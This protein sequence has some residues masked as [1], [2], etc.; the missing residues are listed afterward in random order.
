MSTRN[1][2]NNR[3]AVSFVLTVYNKEY[4]LPA[5]LD[6]VVAQSGDFE[7]EYV[8]VNDGSTDDSLSLIRAFAERTPNVVIVDQ[9]N[10]GCSKAMNAGVNA[11][12]K[13]WIKPVDADDLLAPD[14]TERLL[15]AAH[16]TGCRLVYG[17]N[18][19]Y[20]R[21]EIAD[22]KPP[23][24]GTC[25]AQEIPDRMMFVLRQSSVNPSSML[26][27]SDLYRDVGGCDPRLRYLQDYSLVLKAAWREPMAL[28]PAVVFWKPTESPGRVSDNKARMYQNM[29]LVLFEFLSR[30]P[31]LPR[32]YR[33]YALRRAAGRAYLFARRHDTHPSR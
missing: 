14:T 7:R 17:R 23:P 29:N 1:N 24:I 4:F 2:S 32:R 3:P 11:A 13:Q 22:F 5:V 33:R 25:A 26:I 12:G 28:L 6:A 31:D 15:E 30:N 10:G 8:I 20:Q 19:L 18:N 9:P 21:A 27:A 16:T